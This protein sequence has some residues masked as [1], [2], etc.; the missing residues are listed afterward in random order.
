MDNNNQDIKLC[1]ICGFK[2][3][4]IYK[5]C[6]ECGAPLNQSYYNA[7]GNDGAANVDSK[8][9]TNY[10]TNQNPQY[11]SD[12]TYYNGQF[13]QGGYT[14][15][16]PYK[17][18]I[19]APYFGIPDFNGVSAKD[20]YEFTGGKTELFDKLKIQHF[21][22]K[23]GPY[24][25]PLFVLGLIFSFFGMGCWFLYH[26]MYKP[27]IGFFSAAIVDMVLRCCT[28]FLV[29]NSMTTEQIKMMIES[30]DKAVDITENLI[31][32]PN[33]QLVRLLNIATSVLGVV[34]F[35]FVI[36]FPFFAYK[37][38]K[39]YALHKICEE[40]TKSPMPNIIA[41]GGSNGTL[42]AISSVSYA[43]IFIVAVVLVA[44]PFIKQVS[45]AIPTNANDN[46]PGYY[47]EI[48]DDENYDNQ[49]PYGEEFP[50]DEDFPF[51]EDFQF[52]EEFPFGEDDL[53]GYD[54]GQG[55]ELP[56]TEEIPKGEYW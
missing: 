40:Y 35:V 29:F 21:T 39:N 12:Q 56:F 47:N 22:G 42:V 44:V 32:N 25:W 49:L 30:P 26:K 54:F 28:I 34:A 2:N 23:N 38:Y 14:P 15:Y 41:K 50:F 48:P 20:V 19:N 51:G 18:S 4:S 24:C 3:K 33:M 46:K 45:K 5:Y 7:A 53:Y 36:V 55:E 17:N 9:T 10:N 27:A 16:A 13:V 1:P 6:N 11:N 52:G 37:W 8:Q 31:N 43:A